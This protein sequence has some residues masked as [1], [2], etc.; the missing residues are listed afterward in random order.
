M[1]AGDITLTWRPAISQ[2]LAQIVHSTCS[3]TDQQTD[4]GLTCQNGNFVIT[5]SGGCTGTAALSGSCGVGM[6]DLTAVMNLA[7]CCMGRITVTVLG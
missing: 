6:T 4:V 2:W 7:G 1:H 3:G 5:F